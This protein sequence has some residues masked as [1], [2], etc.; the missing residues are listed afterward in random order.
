MIQIHI[1]Y[2]LAVLVVSVEILTETELDFFRLKLGE[3]KDKKNYNSL[4]LSFDKLLTYLTFK[5]HHF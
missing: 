3:A 4:L 2:I 5:S 1:L